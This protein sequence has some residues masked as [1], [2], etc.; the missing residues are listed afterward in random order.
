M[1]EGRV[2]R[3]TAEVHGCRLLNEHC[4]MSLIVVIYTVHTLQVININQSFTTAALNVI[5]INTATVEWTGNDQCFCSELIK[6][7]TTSVHYDI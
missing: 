7:T 5:N 1:R 6:K 3:Q 4:S 2:H